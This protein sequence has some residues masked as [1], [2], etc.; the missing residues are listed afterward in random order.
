MKHLKYGVS[1]ILIINPHKARCDKIIFKK[2]YIR[3]EIF[4]GHK[5]WHKIGTLLK[6]TGINWHCKC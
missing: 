4:W 1:Y 2:V 5:N 3:I 6:F